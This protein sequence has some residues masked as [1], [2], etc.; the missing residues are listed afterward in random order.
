MAVHAKR[1]TMETNARARQ[2]WGYA[3][4]HWRRSF[5]MEPQGAMPARLPAIVATIAVMSA[6]VAHPSS[7]QAQAEPPMPM[8]MPTSTQTPAQTPVQARAPTPIVIDQ[9][10][11]VFGHAAIGD[12]PGFPITLG[13]SGH[14]RLN[15]DLRVPAGLSGIVIKAPDVTLDLGGHTVHGPV[16]CTPDETTLTVACNAPSRFSAVV[17]ISSVGG[18]RASIVNGT[19]RGFAGLGLHVGDGAVLELLQVRSNAGVGIASGGSAAA[20]TVRAVLVRHN[21][22]AG[23]VCEQMRIERSTFASNGGTGV[24]CVN[25]VFVNGVSRHNGGFGVADGSRHGLRSFGNR[26][27]DESAPATDRA[28]AQDSAA[29]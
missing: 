3:C 21:G 14:Y 23:I 11:A 6:L 25:S 2:R 17:G 16:D 7:S 15:S 8:P 13:R 19:V 24:D 10:S 22:G 27:G 26:L 9:A 29:R 1:H 20:G 18:A 28:P 4:G 5:A 12:A